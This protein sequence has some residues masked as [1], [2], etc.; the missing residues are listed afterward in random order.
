MV[1][2]VIIKYQGGK[3]QNQ[4]IFTHTVTHPSTKNAPNMQIITTM[5]IA[6]TKIIIIVMRRDIIILK[7]IPMVKL[8][9]IEVKM[10]TYNENRTVVC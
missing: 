1:D 7:T 9:I 4:M 8:L 5:L 2:P 10:T 6:F 3:I